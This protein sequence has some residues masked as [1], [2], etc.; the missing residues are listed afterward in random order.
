MKQQI[1]LSD[2]FTSLNFDPNKAPYLHGTAR[3]LYVQSKCIHE[4]LFSS[5]I[6][7]LQRSKLEQDGK[8]CLHY[9]ALKFS[10]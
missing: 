8:E 4:L 5:F 10:S 9:A 7:T 6:G 2:E 1:S 3:R